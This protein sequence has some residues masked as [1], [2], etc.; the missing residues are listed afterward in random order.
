[1]S[2]KPIKQPEF[3]DDIFPDHVPLV[4]LNIQREKEKEEQ[5]K[6]IDRLRKESDFIEPLIRTKSGEIKKASKL[7]IF[8]QE[9][10]FV[11][12][13]KDPVYYIETSSIKFDD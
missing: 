9:E 12:C 7:T 10:E 11:K 2:T 6:I 13:A 5:R 1:M 8:E 4:P 3:D